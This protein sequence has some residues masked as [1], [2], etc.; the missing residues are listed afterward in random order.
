MGRKGRGEPGC[1]RA[2]YQVGRNDF[3]EVAAAFQK[4]QQRV[5]FIAENPVV[6]DKTKCRAQMRKMD[7][8]SMHQP[9]MQ[10]HRMRFEVLTFIDIDIDSRDHRTGGHGQPRQRQQYNAQQSLDC[11]SHAN[12]LFCTASAIRVAAI[13]SVS[14]VAGT[15]EVTAR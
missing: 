11:S 10:V 8:V 6:T 9:E 1:F 15:P 5:V 2:L 3:F 4:R 12:R 14:V 7:V 13:W